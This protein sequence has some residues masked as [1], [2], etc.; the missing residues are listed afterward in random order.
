MF[1]GRTLR[2]ADAE[3]EASFTAFLIDDSGARVDTVSETTDQSSVIVDTTPPA[4]T[5]VNV[6]LGVLQPKLEVP[7]IIQFI[8][9]EPLLASPRV[10]V[11]GVQ[12]ADG[13]VVRDDTTGMYTATWSKF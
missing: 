8:A 4:L 3:G 10:A 5:F 6:L 1:W 7:V 12:L 2:S 9:N 13:A 11:M